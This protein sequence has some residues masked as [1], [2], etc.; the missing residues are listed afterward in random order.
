LLVLIDESGCPGFKL[1]KGS[2]PYFV[3]AMVIFDDYSI[4]EK[5]SSVIGNLR[6]R[7]GVK[8]EFKFNKSSNK[9]R[10]IFFQTMSQCNFSVRALVVKKEF[11]HSPYLRAKKNKCYNFFVRNLMLYDGNCLSNA[12]V[13]IDGRGNKEFQNAMVSYLRKQIGSDKVRKY[14]LVNSKKDN[15]IQL[16]DMIVG[17]IARSFN[18]NRK[19]SNYWLDILRRNKKIKNIWHF[20]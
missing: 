19:N 16:A 14:K 17:A 3:L 9:I 2:T 7:L 6:E 1:N 12:S 11:I 5:T 8:P 20:H 15:L 13:K 4:A 10:D 18:D